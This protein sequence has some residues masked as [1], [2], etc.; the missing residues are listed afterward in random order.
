MKCN[1]ISL[2]IVFA[3]TEQS[4]QYAVTIEHLKVCDHCQ[5][6]LEKMYSQDAASCELSA[7]LRHSGEHDLTDYAPMAHRHTYGADPSLGHQLNFLQPASHPELLGRIGRYDV[8]RVVGS[9]GTGIV[10]KAYDS[11]LHRVVALKVLAAH[12]A[13]NAL[14]RV[15]FAR[16]ARAAAAVLHP[17]VLPIYNVEAN[18]EAPYLVMQYVP[19]E[20]LQARVDRLGPLPVDESLRIAKQTAAAIAAAHQQGLIHRDVKPAN[21]LLEDKTDRVVL[22]DFGLARSADDAAVTSTGFVAGTP[23]YMS[24]EQA[25]GEPFDNRT[26]LFSL[27]SVLYFML[28]GRPPFRGNSAI[29]VLHR[30]CKYPHEAISQL[31]NQVPREVC[32]LVDVLLRKRPQQ[33]YASANEVADRLELLLSKH[34]SGS[35]SLFQT[36]RRWLIG[37][38]VTASILLLIATL[39]TPLFK[40]SPDPERSEIVSQ[41]NPEASAANTNAAEVNVEQD[42]VNGLIADTSTQEDSNISIETIDQGVF[43]LEQMLFEMEINPIMAP[44]TKAMMDALSRKPNVQPH[45]LPTVIPQPS[46][47]V[48]ER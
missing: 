2:D 13:H 19:G 24:P 42:L 28:T 12:L 33:R 16:E 20:S 35:L 5:Q 36:D 22:S 34:Q 6:K 21:I 4:D 31:N 18:G 9:G 14:S 44:D 17:N 40:H 39:W 27:G 45:Y 37:G 30:V 26:D 46:H 48:N 41:P 10:L 8:E 43:E 1:D 38:L 32:Q 25:S 47:G 23:Q 7:V 15:R 29:A 3:D 11:E